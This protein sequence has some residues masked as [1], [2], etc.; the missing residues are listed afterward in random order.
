MATVKTGWWSGT[1]NIRVGMIGKLQFKEQKN[2]EIVIIWLLGTFRAKGH[3][4][5]LPK[6]IAV[7]DFTL[8]IMTI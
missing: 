1:V 2:C 5:L 7:Q 6:L 4:V 3:I 8:Q